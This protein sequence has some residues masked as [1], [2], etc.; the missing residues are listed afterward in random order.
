MTS[1]LFGLNVASLLFILRL[2]S[3]LS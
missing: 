3:T 2:K 1:K